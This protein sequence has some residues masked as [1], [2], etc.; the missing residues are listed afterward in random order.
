MYACEPCVSTDRMSSRPEEWVRCKL[1]ELPAHAR[2]G[3]FNN[4]F[5]WSARESREPK[6]HAELC[7]VGF[8]SSLGAEEA[9]HDVVRAAAKVR[10]RGLQNI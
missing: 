10:P 9:E 7:W 8:G 3:V 2:H 1:S 4:G 6:F 5:R